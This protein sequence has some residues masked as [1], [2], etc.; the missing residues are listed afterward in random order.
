MRLN[1]DAGIYPQWSR[2]GLNL[3]SGQALEAARRLSSSDK[4][5]LTALHCHLGTYVME[6]A[7]YARQI[8]KMVAFSYE[9]Q[10]SFGFDIEQLDI[11]GGFPSR[12][13]LKGTYLPPDIAVPSIDEYA[14]QITDALLKSLRPGD[15]P[16]LVLEAGRAL[17][18]EAGYLVTTI[19][20]T[21]RLPD[22]TRAYVADAGVNLF[23]TAYW[24]KPNIELDREVS[25]INE[26]SVIYGP[27]CMNID[28]MDEA[29]L[30]PPLQRGTRLILSPV[31]AYNNTQWMQFIQYRPN[32]VMV[33]EKGEIDV[34]REAEDL[35]DINSR[36]RMPARFEAVRPA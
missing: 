10:S 31:G 28:V 9:L 21:K 17:I 24:Y 26:S 12:S 1:L 6:P 2:F 5:I 7:A 29:A 16:R 34:I 8:E 36:E 13:R 23:F 25:G 4:I 3:E 20:A 30:L 32:V 18:D 14:E 11:G 19:A 15:M 27:L 35:T 22:G 33:G